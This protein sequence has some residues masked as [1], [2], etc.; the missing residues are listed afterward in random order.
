MQADNDAENETG[1]PEP[2]GG[3]D[4]DTNQDAERRLIISLS[5]IAVV[6]AI[7]VGVLLRELYYGAYPHLRPQA[8]ISAGSVETCDHDCALRRVRELE[9]KLEGK[10]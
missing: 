8:P 7:G 4:G 3:L 9:N 1:T 5:I 6:T 2:S 10:R